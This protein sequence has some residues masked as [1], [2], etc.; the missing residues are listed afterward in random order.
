MYIYIHVCIFTYNILDVMHVLH[1]TP[2]I[3]IPLLFYRNFLCCFL[4]TVSVEKV[5]SLFSV[6]ISFPVSPCVCLVL[7]Y[8]YQI[9]KCRPNL[10]LPLNTSGCIFETHGHSLDIIA[11]RMRIREWTVFQDYCLIYRPYLN[12][13]NSPPSSLYRKKKKDNVF[14]CW[15]TVQDPTA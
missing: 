8:N 9:V 11:A 4:S 15:A 2:Q 13:D 7:F 1:Y 14:S 12:F 3:H 6:F 5:L 10:H